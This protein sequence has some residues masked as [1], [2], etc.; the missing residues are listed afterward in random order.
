MRRVL[1]L[2]LPAFLVWGASCAFLL[3][4]DELKRGGPAAGGGAAGGTEAGTGGEV[5]G[6]GG[7]G[8]RP[9]G[10]ALDELAPRLAQAVCTNLTACYASL[11]E[12]F[13]HDQKCEEFFTNVLAD[14]T[15][16]PIRRSIARGTIIYDPLGA[17]E[18]VRDLT[19]GADLVPPD[20]A[21][22]NL[23]I[24]NCKRAFGNLASQGVPCQERFDCQHGLTCD[25]RNSCPGTCRP[26]A[27]KDQRCLENGDCDPDQRLYCQK[28]A[29]VS[30]GG[31]ASGGSDAGSASDAGTTPG[32]SDA[33]TTPGTCQPFVGIN[34]AC[35]DNQD[36]CVPGAMCI[37]R[38]CRR[39]N[40]VFTLSEGLNCYPLNGLLCNLG[41]SCEYSGIPLLSTSLCVAEKQP[42]DACKLAFPSECPPRTYCTANGANLGG[43]CVGTPGEN[44]ACAAAPEQ[45][46]GISAACLP[47]LTCLSGICRPLQRLD[48]P[49]EA[50][51]QCYSGICQ[52]APSGGPVCVPPG[53]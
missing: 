25:L 5:T 29:S 16:A 42:L 21:N 19:R 47:G 51:T 41:L 2:A 27:Q 22:V 33:G 50:P 45:A 17:T 4:F 15:V 35:V 23:A 7:E 24:E 36:E 13:V 20:C 9:P 39:V 30:D 11:I 40:D 49:C 32:A 52:P 28:L 37:G 31:V 3:D 6:D 48:Q 26:F 38:V 34:Q 46:S 10:I 53:C 12:L 43:Q 18:C 1:L 14:Q 8:G 44:Q